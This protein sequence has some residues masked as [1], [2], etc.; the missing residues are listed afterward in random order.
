MTYEQV[1]TLKPEAF[2]RFCGVQ[3][4]T[5][6]EMVSVLKQKQQEKYKPGRPAKLSLKDQVGVDTENG[7]YSTLRKST[8]PPQADGCLASIT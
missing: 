4:A 5:F 8:T 1:R 7:K 3:T 6:L 2:K